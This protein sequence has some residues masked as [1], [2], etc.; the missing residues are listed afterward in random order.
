LI[1]TAFQPNVT[2]NDTRRPSRGEEIT[3]AAAAAVD[4]VEIQFSQLQSQGSRA[5]T[6]SARVSERNSFPTIRITHRQ[7]R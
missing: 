7:L 3:G 4:D 2:A 5:G 6:L 1:S